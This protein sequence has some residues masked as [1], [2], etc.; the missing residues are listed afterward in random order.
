MKNKLL[1]SK[2]LILPIAI[3]GL[4]TILV[5]AIFKFTHWS[6]YGITGSILLEVGTVFSLLS[7]IVVFIDMLRNRI[8]YS[9]L[10]IIGLLFFFT[11]TPVVY[12]SI[13]KEDF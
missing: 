2:K 6:F 1:I 9:V 10:W 7:W 8:K 12:L 3:L 5:G 11:L 4:L 13:R